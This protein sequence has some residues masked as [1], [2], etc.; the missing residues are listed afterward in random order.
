MDIGKL[1][2]RMPVPEKGTGFVTGKPFVAYQERKSA[3]TVLLQFFS[4][5]ICDDLH[6]CYLLSSVRGIRQSW[7]I[8]FL[9]EFILTEKAE[10]AKPDILE[11]HKIIR[12]LHKIVM[13]RKDGT[14][15]IKVQKRDGHSPEIFSALR[16]VLL[17]TE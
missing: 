7:D 6:R 9:V 2:L 11:H 14:V 15:I 12:F 5:G 17:R 13:D 10:N 16:S 1:D 3:V 8:A 4:G